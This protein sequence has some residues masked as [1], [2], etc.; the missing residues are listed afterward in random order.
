MCFAHFDGGIVR[1]C[2]HVSY[3]RLFSG[4]KYRNWKKRYFV[5]EGTTLQYFVNKG[6]AVA[7]GNIDLS[8]GRGVRK[9][10][11]CSLEWPKE[12]K[13]GLCFGLAT[14]GRTYYLYGTDKTEIE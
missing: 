14:E 5:F 9:R 6:D 7:R 4:G 2:V 1:V 10:F 11:Q 12:A 13:N 8:S 3:I